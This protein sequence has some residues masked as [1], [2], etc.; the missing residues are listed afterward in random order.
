MDAADRSSATVIVVAANARRSIRRR[1]TLGWRRPARHSV[2]DEAIVRIVQ[3]T[4]KTTAY[5]VN[6]TGHDSP[7]WG[8]DGSAK[9][10]TRRMQ[11]I[12]TTYRLRAVTGRLKAVVNRKSRYGKTTRSASSTRTSA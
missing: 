2:T 9:D 12:A 6:H 7:D 11:V 8:T 4:R 3:C 5:A 10:Q 1:A